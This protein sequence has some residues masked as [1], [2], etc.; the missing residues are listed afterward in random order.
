MI[1]VCCLFFISFYFSIITW[2]NKD[3]AILCQQ[4]SFWVQILGAPAGESLR[5]V[6]IRSQYVVGL[7]LRRTGKDSELLNDLCRWGQQMWPMPTMEASGQ[8][9]GAAGWFVLMALIPVLSCERCELWGACSI[10]PVSLCFFPLLAVSLGC[11][12][13]SV[14]GNGMRPFSACSSD[15][16]TNLPV[17]QSK[18][19]QLWFLISRCEG[20]CPL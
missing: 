10:C 15:V 7:T 2:Q 8:Q 11:P 12:P 1:N 3:L 19:W 13:S 9:R 14:R 17:F 6:E 18:G 4:G 5:Y 20:N 16:I